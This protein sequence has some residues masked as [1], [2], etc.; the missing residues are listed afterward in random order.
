MVLQSESFFFGDL[1]LPVFDFGVEELFD[2]PAVETH[3]VVV[4]GAFVKLKYRLARLKVRP[5]QDA[6]LLKLGENPVDG[7]QTNI[8]V[9]GE[10]DAIDVFGTKMPRLGLLE[11]G[12]H[13]QSGYGDLQPCIFK[14]CGKMLWRCH[15]AY[16]NEFDSPLRFF[17]RFRGAICLMRIRLLLSLIPLV[18][19]GCT[20]LEQVREN[21]PSWLTP[22][23]PD[24]GQGNFLSQDMVDQLRPGMGRD[25]VRTILGTPLLV[26]PFRDD[27]WDYVF[28][29]RRGDGQR[30]RRRF[31]VRFDRD[32]LVEWGGDP[33]P[34]ASGDALLPLRPV[35]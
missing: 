7:R 16:D 11:N 30:E 32:Q 9:F 28:D 15:A 21:P 19:S 24:I 6:R 27:R 35:R 26:D 22:Y 23:R 8:H 34:R 12:K 10:H 14:V 29:I 2:P 31:F 4:V 13:L 3:Q 1:V 18:L 5:Q 17:L 33:L 20:A 25:A